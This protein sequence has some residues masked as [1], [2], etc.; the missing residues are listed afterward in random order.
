LPRQTGFDGQAHHPFILGQFVQM[1]RLPRGKTERTLEN[2]HEY[3]V[4]R[5][6]MGLNSSGFDID[7]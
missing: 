3:S 2:L 5:P 7:S 6:Q 4:S 1:S